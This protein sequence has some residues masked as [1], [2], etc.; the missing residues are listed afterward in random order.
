[1]SMRVECAKQLPRHLRIAPVAF[2]TAQHRRAATASV[3]SGVGQEIA[4]LLETD[5][6]CRATEA[7]R[8]T[9]R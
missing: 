6:E 8:A 9:A 3:G 7:L 5:S 4:M 1:M 2:A